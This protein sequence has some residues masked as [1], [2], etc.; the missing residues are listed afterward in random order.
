MSEPNN[1][2]KLSG[3][4]SILPP[5]V[6]LDISVTTST[7]KALVMAPAIGARTPPDKTVPA[8][9]PNAAPVA[10][11]VAFFIVVHPTAPQQMAMVSHIL[12]LVRTALLSLQL[13]LLESLR[14]NH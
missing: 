9:A 6:R 2:Q 14:L 10:T 13:F 1:D 12:R 4:Q 7:T 5:A 8:V 11:T 3:A